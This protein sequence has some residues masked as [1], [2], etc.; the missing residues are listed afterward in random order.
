[1]RTRL[2]AGGAVL[3]LALTACGATATA[4]APGA[5]QEGAAG[6]VTVR[7]WLNGED[8]PAEARDY[9]V[10]EFAAANP[11]A[12]LEIEQQEWEGLVE[13][14]TTALSSDTE[15]PDVVEIGNTQAPTFTSVGAF[16]DLTDRLDEWGG[17]DLLPGF[18][19]GATVDGATYAVP[20]YAGSKVVYYRK[21]LLEAAG[22][23]VPTTL[24]QFVD[25]AAALKAAN[26]APEFSGFWFPGQDWRNGVA[27]VWAHGG[28]IATADG[29]AWSGSLS[30]PQSQAGLARAQE[31]FATSGAG[32][33]ANEEDPQV[34]FCAG[35]AAMVSAPGWL[36]GVLEDPETGCPDLVAD[37][38][39]FA[40]P[41]LDGGVAPV[42]LGGSDIAVSAASQH[43]EEALALVGIML[44]EEY[45][46]ILGENGL[47]PARTSLAGLLGDDEFA[48]AA[49]AAGAGAK[50]TP[51]AAGWAGVEG[52]RTMEDLFV[53]LANGGDPAE[54]ARQADAAIDAAL[55][56][57]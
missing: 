24:D 21:S 48:Q 17:D 22:L 5:A 40:L 44:S 1:M 27:L 52:A 29:D 12:T 7:L 51:S 20:Y 6:P 30:S 50:L 14:L 4:T 26:P 9:L 45:Q 33:D 42:L 53:G 56:R 11:G 25:T 19:E 2:A 23:P 10:E 15:T 18:V 55:A 8:T 43:Q 41:G 36:L 35:Q 46:T 32:K 37:I 57:G 13:R 49:I 3:A 47:T 28:E 39:A 16:S 38:G 31:L 54:L 34:P